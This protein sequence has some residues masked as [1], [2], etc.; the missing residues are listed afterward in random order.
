MVWTTL[1]EG[2][3]AALKAIGLHTP[4]RMAR[5]ELAIPRDP[6]HGDWTTNLALGLAREAK[7]PPRAVAEALAD[8]FPRDPA[9]FS[10]VEVAGPGFLNFRYSGAFLAALPARI[11]GEGAG[12]G[13]SALTASERVLV[14]YVSANPT[15]PLNVV[16]ARAAAVGATLVRLLETTGHHAEGEFYVNDAGRQVELLGESMAARFAERVGIPRAMPEDGYQG[17]YLLDLA[18][19]LP[20]AEARAALARSDIAWF[21]DQALERVMAWQRE[22]L[23]DYGVEFA[24]WY[25]ESTLHAAHAV[26]E[27]LAA[28]E[29]RGVVYRAV[30][31]ETGADD[32]DREGDAGPA[33]AAARGEATWLRTS[34]FGDEKDRVL[35]RDNGVPTYLLPDIAYHR[36][37][38]ARGFQRAID[39]WGPDH[40][41][42]IGRM[43]A[44][45][46]ALGHPGFLE[47]LIAQQVNLLSAGQPVKMSKRAGEFITL[48]GLMNEVGADCAKFFFLM[49][50]T[51]AHLDFDLD[52]AR[53]QNDENPAYYVQYAHARIA[54]LL[55]FAGEKGLTPASG[56]VPDEELAVPEVAALVR[57]LATWPEVVRGAAAAREP[58]RIPTYLMETAA[59]FHR[60][61]HACRVVTE[62][63]ERSRV[64]LLVAGAARQ[65]I[66]NGLALLGVGAPERMERAAEVAP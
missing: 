47:V 53:Q 64:R 38:Q 19:A 16:N 14:E 46:Q 39:I 58:H 10:A 30:V 6:A 32:A 66:A 25:R 23:K 50:S 13:R 60:Y 27:T 3:A 24:R 8:A 54:S 5:L 9:L 12:F 35:V 34:K 20:E 52:L 63:R 44:A 15:G 49:R 57:K 22:D 2:L 36:D 37:K 41:G 56:T 31:P 11:A 28:L 42:H 40:H 59:E 17:A 43:Q 61:Y 26:E 4:E 18:A 33:A 62:D 48:R 51:S 65:V 55:R 29:A 21:R 45:L 1:A 7:R